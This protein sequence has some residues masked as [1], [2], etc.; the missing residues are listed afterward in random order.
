MHA[1]REVPAHL[2]AS[3]PAAKAESIDGRLATLEQ[4]FRALEAVK[5]RRAELAH[6]RDHAAGRVRMLVAA[7]EHAEEEARKVGAL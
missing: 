5:N 6:Y 2:R 7:V 4:Q 3:E 1:S